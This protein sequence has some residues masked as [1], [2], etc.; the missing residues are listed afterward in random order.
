MPTQKDQDR[1]EVDPH[2]GLRR[3]IVGGWAPEKHLRLRKYVDITRAVRGKFGRNAT[4]IDLY[5]GPG[6]ARLREA[7]DIVDGSAIVAA[8]EA[9]S[10]NPYRE[11]I[12]GDLDP[13]NV[14][15]CQE[16]LNRLG[17]ANVRAFTGTALEVAGKVL[18]T[19]NPT[20]FN[21][22]FLDP[23]NIEALPFGVIE[24]LAQAKHMDLLIHVSIMDLQRNVRSM[25]MS[26][27]LDA[28]APGWEK[29]VNRGAT[30]S[31]L[32][33]QVF[34]HWRNLLASMGYLISDNIE[35]VRGNRNQ[36]LYWLVLAAK[37]DLADKLWGEVSQVEPQRRLF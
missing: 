27:K 24:T 10:K 19:L 22:A 30:N 21:L 5:C 20:G 12:I 32:V 9:A 35:R 14:E 16:R 25:M 17:I 7:G 3:A 13:L 15:A 8:T 2:D 36:P 34:E 1:Y 37:H 33:M 29:T 6:R 23:F 11:I 28:F 31:T 18:P 26:G 4:Y